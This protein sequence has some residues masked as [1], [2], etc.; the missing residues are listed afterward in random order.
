MACDVK[1]RVFFISSVLWSN[2]D[3]DMGW[4]PQ[5]ELTSV[6]DSMFWV[7]NDLNDLADD[8]REL[9][10]TNIRKYWDAYQAELIEQQKQVDVDMQKLYEKITGTCTGKSNRDWKSNCT[11]CI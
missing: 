7:F 2:A 6:E 9:Y 3:R 10:G 11:G 5:D 4:I 1:S 8:N